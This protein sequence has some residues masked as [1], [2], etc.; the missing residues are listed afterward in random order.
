[1]RLKITIYNLYYTLEPKDVIS[2]SA[3]DY[4]LTKL[5]TYSWVYDYRL[6]RNTKVL[7]KIYASIVKYNNSYRF[8]INTLKDMMSLLAN[9]GLVKED[10][11]ISIDK[12]Y[13]IAAIDGVFNP[14]IKLRPHQVKCDEILVKDTKEKFQLV[15]LPPGKG[16]TIIALHAIMRLNR[17]TLILILPRYIEKWISDIKFGTDTKEY[18]IYVIRGRKGVCDLIDEVRET[19]I[20]DLPYKFI[21][22]GTNTMYNYIKDFENNYGTDE[23]KYNSTPDLLTRELG[24]GT[25]LNDEAHQQFHSV[26]KSLLYLDAKQLIALSATLINKD[27]GISKMYNTMFPGDSRISNL[28]GIDRY[29]DI[30]AIMYKLRNPKRVQYRRQ[31]GYNH[32]L[33]ES[34]MFRRSTL[35]RDYVNMILHYLKVGHIDRAKKGEKC[36]I[37]VASINMATLLTNT[38]K[39]KYP[40]YDVRRYVEDDPYENIMDGEITI[41]TIGSSGTAVDIPDLITV[42]Q[43]VS[44]RSVQ[45][46]RQ[47]FGRLRDIGKE[48]RYYQFFTNNIPNQSVAFKESKSILGRLAKSYQHSVYN[49]VLG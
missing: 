2:Q 38:I 12:D 35:L 30:Y 41:S 21:I 33:Y 40:G 15:D 7:D 10:I 45:A 18:E 36:L 3:I 11:H 42:I 44:I 22:I 48:V 47:N 13:D 17:R 5:S 27:P 20:M 43:T 14:E 26:Y 19:G 6:K 49:R 37:F 25:V 24:I 39:R 4:A 32:N 9:K 34:S 46:I 8:N 29:V 16:K 23:Y 28:V 1:M 31:Q